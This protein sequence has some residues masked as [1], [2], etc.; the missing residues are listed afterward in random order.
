[1]TFRLVTAL[2]AILLVAPGVIFAADVPGVTDT[3]VVV[4]ISTPLSGP[5][6]LWG[7]TAVGAKAWADHVNDLGGVNGRKIKVIIKDDGYNPTRAVSNLK[8]F[9]GNVFAI[10][11]LLGSA[12]C[13]ANKDFFAE[14]K[15]PC[16]LPYANVRIWANQPPEKRKWV[17]VAYPDYEDEAQYLSKFALEKLNAR[18]LAIFYQN[19]DY[20]KM[21]M[22]GVEDALKELGKGKLVG[23]VPHELSETSL[24]AHALK[25]KDSGA[26]TVIIYT[27]PKHA[28]LITKEM[29]K[30]AYKPTRLAT[31][32]LADPIMYM[33]AKKPWEGTYIA[34]PANSGVPG[35][36]K[37]ADKVVEAIVKKNPKI[38][39]KEYL[40][41]FGATSM[42]HF[43]E[44]LKRAGKN[45]TQESFIKAM[46][47]I[48][49]WK[50]EGV[51]APVT[52]SAD[53]H[54]GMN[55]S[56][57]GQAKGG[58]HVPLTDKYEIYKPRF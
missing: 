50:P 14:N 46:E 13:N 9:K 20:G 45:P 3:E 30:A 17:F 49:D 15:I 34:F 25:L 37:E 57:M 41:L 22:K 42:M 12:P 16:V 48:K 47:T 4:G 35:A 43:L 56:R 11:A 40:G 23:A 24:G 19:D 28:A 31:F 58:K 54:H 26:D 53:R 33:I 2:L 18:K 29:A 55:G 27:N 38:K 21:A 5:A 8:D 32:T 52:Y 44:G 1:M 36:D 6:A 7:I 39:G 51:G 10:C